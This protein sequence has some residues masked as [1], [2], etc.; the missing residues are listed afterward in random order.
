MRAPQRLVS[1]QDI[2]AVLTDPDVGRGPD[3]TLKDIDEA[4]GDF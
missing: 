4:K 1:G 2:A 3:L